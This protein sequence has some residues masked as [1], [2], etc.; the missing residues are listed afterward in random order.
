M[1]RNVFIKTK[2]LKT[3]SLALLQIV[4]VGNLQVLPANAIYGAALPFLYFLAIIGFFIPCSLMVAELATT[5]PQTG[6]SYIWC[7]QA[8][9][10]KMGFF[11]VCILWISNLLWYP[12]IFSL[13]AA[14]FAYLFDV[15][16]AQNKFFIVSFGL[17]FFW[18]FTALNCVGVKFSSKTSVVCSVLGVI[19]PM[20]LI[21][22]GG[23]AWCVSGKPLAVSFNHATVLPDLFHIS[24]PGLLI[25][26][27]ISLFGIEVTA[28]H[29]GNV[30]NPRRDYPI[31]LLISGVAVIALLLFSELAIAVIIPAKQLSVITG[32][33]DA[34]TIVF[35][36]M[37]L[38]K[39]INLILLLVLLGNMGS[40]AAWMLGSTRG[41]YVACQ[42]NHV[43]KFFQKV[44]RYEAPVG[45]LIAEA[46]IFTL[47][48]LI[49]LMMPRV[50]DSFWLLM[51]LASQITLV[52]YIILFVSAIR[53]RHKPILAPGF[54]IPGGN[55]V[56]GLI[57]GLGILVSLLALGVGFLAPD[58]LAAADRRIFHWV[59]W[60]GLGI[61]FLLPLVILKAKRV[62]NTDLPIKNNYN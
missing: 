19:I 49:F 32:L 46:M 33:L 10:S 1:D 30:V 52:Y 50:T 39:Y 35:Q 21:I 9:G 41:M 4:I 59:S 12:T 22:A 55:R 14:N 25:A 37:H 48:S 16:L 40:V 24:N 36:E 42:K 44:N 43:A 2:F 62:S 47:V 27:V 31:S 17:I 57:M 23:I 58:D 38:S 29:A 18:I 5:R 54:M 7:E 34:L 51:D 20:L 53:L 6:G 3:S 15:S 61:A 26:I 13:I 56:Q 45:V 60:I 8:F 28:V 11:T